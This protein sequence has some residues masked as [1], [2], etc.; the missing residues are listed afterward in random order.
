MSKK[1]DHDRLFK[2]LIRTFF[3]EF[4]E[5]FLP[6]IARLMEKESLAFLPEEVFTD[7]TSGDK[8]KIDPLA[9]AR[10]KGK[11]S[12][13]VIHVENQAYA[14]TKFERRMFSY[15]SRLH[16]LYDLPVYPIVVF[17]FD[18]PYKAQKNKY[19]VEFD[20]DTVMQFK[21]TSIQLNR[22]DWA[23]FVK[24]KNPVAAALM[25]KMR[26]PKKERAK[27]KAECLRLLV[28][29]KLDAARTSLIS[30]F[31]DSYLQLNASEKRDFDEEM[32]KMG[33]EEKEEVMEIVTSWMEEGI[34][35]GLKQGIDL[36]LEREV[37]MAAR[38]LGR[39]I[40]A[41]SPDVISDIG[42]LSA[43][44]IEQLFD[45]LLDFNTEADLVSFKGDFASFLFWSL[46]ISNGI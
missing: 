9:R 12:C 21:F 29:L 5:L 30:G 43:K 23:D 22:L 35:R 20:G 26:I 4:L 11:D 6:K 38:M 36:M 19:V 27:V 1:I 2:E 31:V 14:Q 40:G 3:W 45:T 10:F 17:S 34:E 16:D 18:E 32:S 44:Q 7:V 24:R 15:F 8:R 39:Q 37:K 46:G 13:F 41:L 33:L 42:N 25:A 28:N